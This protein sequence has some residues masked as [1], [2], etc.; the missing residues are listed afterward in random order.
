MFESENL[1]FIRSF[2]RRLGF[3]FLF[4]EILRVKKMLTYF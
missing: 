3:S 2:H 1:I 4:L